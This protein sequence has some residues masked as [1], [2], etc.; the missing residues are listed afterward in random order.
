MSPK[1]KPFRI[2]MVITEIQV[3]DEKKGIFGFT[4]V[5]DPRV[6]EKTVIDGEEGYLHKLNRIFISDEELAKAIPS[7]NGKPIYAEKVGIEDKEKYLRRSKERIEK[8]RGR[9]R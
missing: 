2:D 7:L 5:P 8:K 9:K 4:A 3:I 1:K 6:W